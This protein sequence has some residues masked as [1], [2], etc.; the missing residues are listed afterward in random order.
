MTYRSRV[1][2]RRRS[3]EQGGRLAL[4]ATCV[5]V[6]M[7]PLVTPRGP[8]NAAP[9]D[10][11]IV[12]AIVVSLLWLASAARVLK[13]PFGIAVGLS[14]AAGALGAI[15]GPVPG[16]GAVALFQDLTLFCWCVVVVNVAASPHATHTILKTW[17]A[18]GTGWAMVL[19][20]AV[21]SGNP[22]I[23]GVTA[24]NGAR[25]ALT[26]GDA[27]LAASYFF[28]S[29][30]IVWAVQWPVRRAPRLIA[31][32]LL[33][34]ALVMTGSNGGMFVLVLGAAVAGAVG[35]ARRSGAIAGVAVAALFTAAAGASV[36]VVDPDAIQTKARASSVPLIRDSIGRAADSV[37]D[38]EALLSQT[39]DLYREHGG[40]GGGPRS[41]KATLTKLE[42]PFVKEA[43]NDYVAALTERGVLGVVALTLLVG[44]ILYRV[45]KVG[46][47]EPIGGF[48]GVV[49]RPGALVGA[50][51]GT[52][53]AATFYE[54]LH[55][56]HLWTLLALIAA[57]QI[58]GRR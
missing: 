32:L 40:L 43:H 47:G 37:G 23:A 7:L 50:A 36:L 2:L 55:F 45:G 5:A 24:R 28:L 35:V 41:T 10:G 12:V 18:C 30:M 21:L 54:V 25:A 1:R 14:V 13:W 22:A 16:N 8:G 46:F 34:L 11:L 27:N 49:A 44:S 51:V 17:A 20:L 56:R 29:L 38:R 58:W 33:V 48:D 31:Y 19:V 53:T 26:F 57:V 4:G 15:V 39:V 6:A 42:A 52:L 3:H 9:V